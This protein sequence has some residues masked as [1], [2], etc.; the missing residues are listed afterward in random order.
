MFM[1]KNLIPLV[2]NR[3]LRGLSLFSKD[4]ETN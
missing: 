4:V 3:V 2:S 1:L